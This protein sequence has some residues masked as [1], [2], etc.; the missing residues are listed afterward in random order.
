MSGVRLDIHL[1]VGAFCRDL[2]ETCTALRETFGDLAALD[3]ARVSPDVDAEPHDE[4]CELLNLDP[5]LAWSCGC[6]D[7]RRERSRR[8]PERKVPLPWLHGGQ[9]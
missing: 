5:R 2:E 9:R 3:D 8:L 6:P 7:R 4:Q 1:D